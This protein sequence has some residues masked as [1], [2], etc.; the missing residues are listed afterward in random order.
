[1]THNI[2]SSEAHRPSPHVRVRIGRRRRR[3]AGLKT[4]FAAAAAIGALASLI[5]GLIGYPACLAGVTVAF[6][7]WRFWPSRG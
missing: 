3:P 4:W 5:D 7:A 2:V 1:M 6:A